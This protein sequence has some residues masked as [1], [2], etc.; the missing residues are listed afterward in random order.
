VVRESEF[1]EVARM[2]GL[3]NRIQALYNHLT[4]YGRLTDE[5]RN[6]IVTSSRRLMT[7]QERQYL[8]IQG[9]YRNIAQRMNLNPQNTIVDFTRPPISQQERTQLLNEARQAI[10]E[11]RNRDQ[12]LERL[13]HYGVN[14]D[15][16]DR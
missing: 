14:P 12:V 6:D 10:A 13:R 15:E 8:N 2:G 7:E 4:G 16:L 11:G 3:P 1:A 9:Q 5:Q